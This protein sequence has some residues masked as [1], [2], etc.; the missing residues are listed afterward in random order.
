MI[1]LGDVL[2]IVSAEYEVVSVKRC[3]VKFV[4]LTQESTR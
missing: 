4:R 3:G 2:R 1:L